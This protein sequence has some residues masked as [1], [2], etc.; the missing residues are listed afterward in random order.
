[1]E[2]LASQIYESPEMTVAQM[3]EYRIRPNMSKVYWMLFADIIKSENA[4]HI[5]E[6]RVVFLVSK[7]IKHV[8]KCPTVTETSLKRVDNQF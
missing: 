1:M 7:C 3:I 2:N 5:D 4:H 6:L 8:M